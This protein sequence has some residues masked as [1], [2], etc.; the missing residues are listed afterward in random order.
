VHGHPSGTAHD[1]E[2]ILRFAAMTGVGPIT[3]A[4]PLD[5]VDPAYDRMLSSD[6]YDRMVLTTGK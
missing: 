2:E 6:A 3:E 4:R 1:V 5:E